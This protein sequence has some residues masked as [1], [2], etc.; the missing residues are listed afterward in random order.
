MTT[1][2]EVE[3]RLLDAIVDGDPASRQVYADWLEEHDELGRAEFL[4][5]L[6]QLVGMPRAP[7]FDAAFEDLTRQLFV[8]AGDLDVE[9][10][11]TVGRG[12]V[13]KC[14]PFSDLSW[15]I[16]APV[17]RPARALKSFELPEQLRYLEALAPAPQHE[18][19]APKP[20][21]TLDVLASNVPTRVLESL[22]A[23]LRARL[24]A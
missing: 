10:R 21:P 2:R 16:E 19:M 17:R 6:D 13:A 1:D 24:K 20:M 15:A 3:A 23:S 18:P 14:M 12:P 5:V 22:L 7:S 11:K 4:R 8:I 9:W